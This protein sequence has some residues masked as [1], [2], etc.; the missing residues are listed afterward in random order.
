MIQVQRVHASRPSH[1]AYVSV[2]DFLRSTL[3]GKFYLRYLR[4]YTP[5]RMAVIW[6]WKNLLAL[7][8]FT[9]S[10]FKYSKFEQLSGITNERV[11]IYPRQKVSVRMP[12]VYPVEKSSSVKILSEYEF[13]EIYATTINDCTVVGASGFVHTR[14]TIIG[15]NLFRISHDYTSEELHGRLYV[16]SKKQ[17]ITRLSSIKT[18]VAIDQ[19]VLFTDA[20]SSNYAHFMTEILPKV[21]AYT[22]LHTNKTIPLIIDCELHANLMQALEFVVGDSAQLIGLEK[23][24]PLQV[25]SL[26]VVSACGYVPF[27]RRPRS[28][29]FTDHSQ[30]VFSPAALVGMRDLIKKNVANFQVGLGTVLTHKKIWIKRNSTYR[31]V[32]NAS[33]IE[34]ALLAQGFT[35]VE[36]EKLS[37][38]EQ[39]SI[40]SNAE[41]IVGAT[42]A[43]FANLIFCKPEARIIILIAEL[44]DTSYGYWQNIA[45]AVNNNISYVLGATQNNRNNIHA[46]FS[47]NL[48]DLVV[49][50]KQGN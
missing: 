50:I 9:Y 22:Q 27:E 45:S 33:E 7:I 21:F 13:P 17:L 39:V 44:K 41:M 11:T 30:G 5:I 46:N 49:S 40:F 24:E 47:V 16:N 36:P 32:S 10:K 37:F 1:R 8:T 29:Y 38:V 34:E 31:N 20:V 26:Q 6:S 35:V 42:G 15:H 18:E 48:S 12:T 4:Q 43:A 23:G 14:Q 3:L 25:K 28:N 2:L 19:G